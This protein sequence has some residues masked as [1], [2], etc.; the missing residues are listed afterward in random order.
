MFMGHTLN[1]LFVIH[2]FVLFIRECQV[3]IFMLYFLSWKKLQYDD[4]ENTYHF[5]CGVNDRLEPNLFCHK[6]FFNAYS[7]SCRCL[8]IIYQIQYI[9]KFLHTFKWLMV[10]TSG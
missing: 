7:K 1:T 2:W 5:V 3:N 6:V 10:K 9:V 4:E 8:F